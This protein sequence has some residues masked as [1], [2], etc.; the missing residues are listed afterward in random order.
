MN[1]SSWLM[2]NQNILHTETASVK[3]LTIT[4]H[5]TH[6][7]SKTTDGILKKVLLLRCRG[8]VQ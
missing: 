4:A 2:I 5:F 7:I 3:I 1:Y 8:G 6:F